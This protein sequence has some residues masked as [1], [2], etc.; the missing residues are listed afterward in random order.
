MKLTIYGRCPSKKNSRQVVCRGARPYSF[1][2]KQYQ[3][4]EEENLWRLKTQHQETIEH[5]QGI[6]MVIYPPDKR[7]ADLS[8]KFESIADLLVSAQILEDDNWFVVPDV[9]LK[10]GGVDKNNPRVEVTVN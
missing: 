8:N 9:H 5:I 7:K 10:F 6:E 1:P 3:D 4:W 2:S